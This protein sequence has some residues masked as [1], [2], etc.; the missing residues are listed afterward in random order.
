MAQDYDV[1]LK[2]LMR[3]FVRDYVWLAFGNVQ[4]EINLLDRE[5][6]AT[7]LHV[8]GLSRVTIAE[9]TFNFQK[10]FCAGTSSACCPS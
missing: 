10:I 9:E 1:S 7:K 2:V 4:A 3:H 8:D 6:E 5:L